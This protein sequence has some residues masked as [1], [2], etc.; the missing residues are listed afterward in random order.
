[1]Y[2]FIYVYDTPKT[3]TEASYEHD[4]IWG[5]CHDTRFWE[6]YRRLRWYLFV[7]ISVFLSLHP[8]FLWPQLHLSP[9]SSLYTPQSLSPHYIHLQLFS[10][11]TSPSLFPYHIPLC[12]SLHSLLLLSPPCPCPTTFLPPLFF[13]PFDRLS[14][15]SFLC[16]QYD[17]GRIREGPIGIANK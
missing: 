3:V 8:H 11:C 16:G 10:L 9:F 1:M 14:L 4:G 13:F 6:T 2:I 7:S 17:G 12:L 5:S 15:P